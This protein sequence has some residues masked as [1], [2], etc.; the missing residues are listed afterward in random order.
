MTSKCAF[1]R[2][3]IAN[4][5]KLVLKTTELLVS[6]NSGGQAHNQGAG[7]AMLPLKV[8]GKDP[9]LPSLASDG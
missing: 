9:P 2:A 7:R 1:S 5:H 8:L 4:Y 6:Y 3:A